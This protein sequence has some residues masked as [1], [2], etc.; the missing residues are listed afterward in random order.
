MTGVQT[1]A[2]PIYNVLVDRDWFKEV[3]NWCI[4]NNLKVDMT[5][6]YD[7][8]LLDGELL[9]LILKIKSKEMLKFAF[10]NTKLEPVVREKIQLMKDHGI[11]T[12]SDVAFYC[13]C[14]D[15]SMYEDTVY[16]ANVL[17]SLRVNADV[18]FNCDM[19]KT[20]RI[21]ALMKWSWRRQL[22]WSVDYEN[23][24]RLLHT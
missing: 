9:D 7:V 23:Y 16:R 8:R 11:N 14:H 17:K 1:C 15:D 20:Q 4:D 12:K 13:Y 5:Q 2:L 10:D 22:F 24:S 19:P 18:M 21:K 3:A 6:G